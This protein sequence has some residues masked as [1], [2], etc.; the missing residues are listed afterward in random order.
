MATSLSFGLIFATALVLI[1]AP[2]FYMLLARA[3]ELTPSR[4]SGEIESNVTP[5][6]ALPVTT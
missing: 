2:V 4:D 1:L 3:S 6:T 5:E